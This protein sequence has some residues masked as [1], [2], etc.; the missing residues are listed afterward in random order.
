M[1]F[2]S[3]DV[4]GDI[5]K[6]VQETDD[7]NDDVVSDGLWQVDHVLGDETDEEVLAVD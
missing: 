7:L 3:S 5:L 2:G 6:L 4:I 1:D